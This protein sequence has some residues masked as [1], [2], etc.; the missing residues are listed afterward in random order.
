MQY[1]SHSLK[2]FSKGSVTKIIRKA[3]VVIQMDSAQGSQEHGRRQEESRLENW[4][5]KAMNGQHLRQTKDNATK[6]T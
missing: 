2:Y 3:S 5:T 4:K 6:E 1:E